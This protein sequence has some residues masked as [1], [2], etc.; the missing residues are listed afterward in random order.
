MEVWYAPNSGRRPICGERKEE[1]R[2]NGATRCGIH[3]ATGSLVGRTIGHHEIVDLLGEGGMGIVYRARDTR[4]GRPV[5]LKVIRPEFAESVDLQQRLEREAQAASALNH[6]NILTIYE[7]GTDEGVTFIAMEYVPG[8][9]LAEALASGPLAVDRALSLTAQVADALAAAHA[10]GIVHRDL[11]PSNIMLAADGRAKVVD[12]GIAKLVGVESDDTAKT[13]LTA[14]GTVLGSAP[15]MSPEQAAGHGVDERTDIFSLGAVLYEMLSGHRPFRGDGGAET[16]AAVLRDTPAPI[17]GVAPGVARI[18]ERCLVKNPADRFQSAAELKGVIESCLAVA[19]RRE[20]ASVAVMPFANMSGAKE[21]D[22]LCEGLAEEIINALTRV[23]GLRVIARTSSFVVGR[24]GL[25]VREAGARL[26]VESILEGSVRRAGTR[27]RVTAQLVSARDGSHLFSERYDREMTD[28]L[29]LEDDV[30]TAIAERLRGELSPRAEARRRQPVDREAYAA[31]LEGRHHFARGTPEA[32]K[33]AMACYERAIE[34]DPLFA[35]AYDS[36]AELHWFLGFFGNVPPREAFS[37]STW[38]A[39]R[40]LELDDTLAEAH[41]LLGML[42]KELDYNW[43]EVD[44]EFRRA[45]EL[46]PESPLVRLRYAVCGLM[47]RG[48]VVEAMAEL[49]EVVQLDPLSIFARWWLAV[50][51]CLARDYDRLANEAEHMIALD[52]NQFMGH[53]ALGLQ[54]DATGAGDEAVAAL[55]RAHELAGGSPFTLGYF[56]MACG[57]AGCTD[58]ARALLVAA[59]EAAETGYVPPSTFAFGYIGLQD[60]DAAFEWLDRAVEGRDPLI[61]PIKTYY[62]LDAVRDDPRYRALLRKMNLE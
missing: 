44:R 17:P 50:M 60:W 53:W 45:L 22:Y 37:T 25:D 38:Y 52:A 11:K 8:G 7:I 12:F 3:M 41:A 30:A 14:S 42:R 49:E 33:T 19:P 36:L 24:E 20:S 56:A 54:R 46:N 9:T 5:A 62:V 18:L 1:R 55:E 47:P 16:L 26:G 32:L 29:A 51:A 61:M 58:R 15:Y 13:A 10:A 59:T 39:L 27:V 40:A 4:L 6:P 23:P 31:F 48:R 21:D 35:L 2:L 43:P 28:L 57:R 34:R